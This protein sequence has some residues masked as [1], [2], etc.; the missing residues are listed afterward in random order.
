MAKAYRELR[1]RIDSGELKAPAKPLG[2]NAKPE[3]IAA[4]RKENGLP[5][6]PATFVKGLKLA[7]GVVL[8]KQD[9]PLLNSFAELAMKAG[10]NQDTF[11]QATDW[12]YQMNDQ[13][14]AQREQQDGEFHTQALQDLMGEWGKE[15]KS[16]QNAIGNLVALF[17]E[18]LRSN[19]LLSRLPD[20][21]LLGDNPLVNRTLLMLAKELNPASTVL[22]A[23]AGAGLT[24]VE[25]RIAEIEGV[26]GR[27]PDRYWRGSEGE[28][29]QGEYRQLLDAREKMKARAA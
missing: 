9:E 20:G 23:A 24:G 3:E 27:E 18:E 16:N 15:F 13:L 2:E 12:Y 26:M 21:S 17:P 11:N 6:D 10:W 8:G 4:W 1:T 19:F 7:D 29:M 28:R 14:A 5:E 25:S 22:P